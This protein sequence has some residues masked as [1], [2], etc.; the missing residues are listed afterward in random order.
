M[1]NVKKGDRINMWDVTM[2]WQKKMS[3]IYS[4]FHPEIQKG[5]KAG[6]CRISLE[7][8]LGWMATP[9]NL[10]QPSV[11][12][13]GNGLLTPLLPD[14][15]S[16]KNNVRNKIWSMEISYQFLGF[17]C[18]VIFWNIFIYMNLKSDIPVPSRQVYL[19]TFVRRPG[20]KGTPRQAEVARCISSSDAG[21][22]S[23]S[24]VTETTT[25]WRSFFIECAP[26]RWSGS[27]SS[28]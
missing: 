16:W 12:L 5:S 27:I 15:L 13:R 9:H 26:N 21:G 14:C 20:C 3:K 7:P 19:F 1:G 23:K 22:Q 2:N 4:G 17:N 6:F 28:T 10:S 25:G 8:W 11:L 18:A 24:S